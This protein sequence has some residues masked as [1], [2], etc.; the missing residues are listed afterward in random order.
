MEGE[1]EGGEGRG[2]GGMEDREGREQVTNWWGEE[3]D[4]Y[5]WIC[6]VHFRWCCQ[7]VLLKLMP[8]ACVFTLQVTWVIILDISNVFGFSDFLWI[9]FWIFTFLR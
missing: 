7:G 4:L 3:P 1:G 5:F 6:G 2:V 9:F 8:N